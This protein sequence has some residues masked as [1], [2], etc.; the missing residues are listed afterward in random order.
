LAVTWGANVTSR[1]PAS[2][3]ARTGQV[4]LRPAAP[5]CLSSATVPGPPSW[6]SPDARRG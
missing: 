4:P 5:P 1:G 2:A 6:R 3:A